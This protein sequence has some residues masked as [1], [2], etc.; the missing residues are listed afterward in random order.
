[1]K[2]LIGLGI[3]GLALAACSQ[4]AGTPHR[5]LGFWEMTQQA[6]KFPPFKTQYCFDARSERGLPVVPR[7]NANFCKKFNVSRNGGDYV[8]DSDCGLPGL[9]HLVN[10]AVLS[11]DF[12]THYTSTVDANVEDSRRPARNGVHKIVATWA[13]QGPTCPADL[14][15][16]DERLPNGDIVSMASLRQGRFGGGLGGGG[17]GGGGGGAGPGGGPGG[18]APGGAGG[19]GAGGGQGGAGASP[20]AGGGGP[21]GAGQ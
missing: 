10:H 12:S 7:R 5:K 11:G 15:P 8:V 14:A 21:P 9:F 3:A 18:G 4:L 1:M 2:R 19:P 13:Y 20:A 16:G 6:D 17:R